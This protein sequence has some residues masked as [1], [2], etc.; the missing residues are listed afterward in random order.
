MP[1]RPAQDL[2]APSPD[3]QDSFEQLRVLIDNIPDVVYI[4]D[5]QSRFIA[6]NV[7]MAKL[8]G[9]T[10][11]EELYGKTDF[12]FCEKALAEAYFADEQRL[13]K[14]GE[15]IQSK[16]E[17]VRSEEGQNLVFRV[18]KTPLRDPS[19]KIYGLVGIGRNIT[20]LA[21]ANQKLARQSQEL[22]NRNLEVEF[23]RRQL[24]TLID[25]IPDFI[26][27][28]DRQSRFLNGNKAFYHSLKA[29]SIEAIKGMSDLDF[30]PPEEAKTFLEGETALMEKGESVTL[31]EQGTKPDGSPRYLHTTKTPIRNPETDEVIGL[32]GITRDVTEIR[33]IRRELIQQSEALK[34]RSEETEFQ[35]NQLQ[36]LINN[37]PDF[38]YF[39]DQQ[40]KF[41]NGNNMFYQGL[42]ASTLEEIIGKTDL[43]YLPEEIATTFYEDERQMMLTGEPISKEEASKNRYGKP[44]VLHTT[45]T[46]IRD[47]ETNEVVGFVGIS[48]DITEVT[49]NRQILEKQTLDLQRQKEEVSAA[50]AKLKQAQT[51]LVQS[52]KMASLGVLTAGI[53]H[54][55]NNPI[56]FVYAGVNSMVK[57]FD[58]VK[59]IVEK[60]RTLATAEDKET[61]VAELEKLRETQYFD[62]AF[63]ALEETLKDIKL[64]ATRITEIV[65]G[66]SKFSRL[67]KEDWQ[68]SDIHSD[69]DSVL[70]LLKNKYKTH[71]KIEKRYQQNLPRIECFPGKLNQ[72]FMNILS[73]A[74]DAIDAK[75]KQGHI[76]IETSHDEDTV[77]ISIKDDGTGMTDEVR[78]KIF[79]PFFTTKEIGKGVGLGLAITYSIIQDHVGEMVINTSEGDG[80]EF[81]VKLPIRQ[82]QSN[83]G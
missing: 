78:E 49:R 32:V 4:K 54:E 51:K 65:A 42:G 81:L 46:P 68:V 72:A 58:D 33:R 22:K 5:R 45:K 74:I 3:A 39:K 62:D 12:D 55:I 16:Q 2:Q 14:T 71:I 40:S 64:G 8:F 17:E 29:E 52:E 57:D 1:T 50:L 43:D 7:A 77:T 70:V 15:T 13:F 23:E 48:R 28:K 19:G 76:V 69:I 67:G 20:D 26:Y 80:S 35:R 10:K 21:S 73:N 31:E 79:D 24:K 83:K 66:L 18:S 27:F 38:I 60:M 59:I 37:I 41:L 63:E 53:A 82:K 9:K 25:N 56:N 75:A 36:T 11:V 30:F 44:V 61:A 34:K 6:A 47:P